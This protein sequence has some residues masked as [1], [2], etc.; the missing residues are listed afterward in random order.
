MTVLPGKLRE[1]WLFP[2]D[3]QRDA[4]SA[5]GASQARSMFAL[6]TGKESEISL[7]A[8]SRRVWKDAFKP[9]S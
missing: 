7:P 6:F 8:G 2:Q 3:A 1:T 9:D 4:L 5:K